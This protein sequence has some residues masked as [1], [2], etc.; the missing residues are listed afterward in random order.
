MNPSRPA[1]IGMTHD[2]LLALC[3]LAGVKRA[4]AD[5]LRAHIF[6]RGNQDIHAIS[7]LPRSF[8]HFLDENTAPFL[9]ECIAAQGDADG[10]R[11]L[12]LRMDDGR[13]VESVLIPGKGRL[14]QC[15]STQIGCAVGCG[16]C[17]TAT[18]GLTRNL[19]TA[20][21]VG[22]IFAAERQC[23]R[24]ARNIVL[25][26]MGEPLHNYD[27]VAKFVRI[28]TDPAGMAFSPKRV[29]LSTAGHV[30]GIE[31]M[32][33]D[34]LPCNLALSLNAADDETR[35]RIMP[36]NQRWPIEATLD[37]VRRFAAGRRK[38]ILIEY[39]LLAGVNDDT[40]DAR[41]LCALLADLDCTVNLLPFNEFAGSDFK[42]PSD[43]RVSAFRRVLSEAGR[44]AVVRE[45]RGRKISAACGQLRTEIRAKRSEWMR[46]TD[47][48]AART[49]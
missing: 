43:A 32:I 10:T 27:A 30:P 13:E 18:G 17:L 41:R 42:R 4:H 46:K 7:G 1:L 20:E 3:A 14:T 35:S 22:Q 49:G 16:F 44:V 33:E 28:V 11:K 23:G 48:A 12:L 34:A 21:I 19:E 45:S 40:E 47:A 8:Y 39:V 37:A 25:M 6:R 36:I 31:R 26:G 5:T 9:P 15:V 2:E 38:R 29:T 24:R